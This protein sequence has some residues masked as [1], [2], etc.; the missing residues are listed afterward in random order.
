MSGTWQRNC[1]SRRQNVRSKVLNV[2][3]KALNVRSKAL[4]IRS[5]V[6]N[7]KCLPYAFLFLF[8]SETFLCQLIDLLLPNRSTPVAER[9][10]ILS[11]PPDE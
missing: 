9:L 1:L 5:K 3:S 2:R 6:L 7:R 8:D 10:S 11:A 4:N